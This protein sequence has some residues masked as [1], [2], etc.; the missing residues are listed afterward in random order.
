M[1]ELNFFFLKITLSFTCH[2]IGHPTIWLNSIRK[3]KKQHLESKFYPKL[4]TQ[5]EAQ[6]I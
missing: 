6:G 2:C 1:I 4:N 5:E 3:P